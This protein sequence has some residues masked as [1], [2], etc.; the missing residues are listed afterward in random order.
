MVSDDEPGACVG[1]LGMLRRRWFDGLHGEDG[2]QVLS[3]L[4]ECGQLHT[5]GVVDSEYEYVLTQTVWV[6]RTVAIC[7][8]ESWGDRRAARNV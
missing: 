5:I 4:L 8:P 6:R 7:R 1:I 3:E 2:L